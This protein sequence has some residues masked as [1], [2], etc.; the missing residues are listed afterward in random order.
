MKTKFVCVV[1]FV[2]IVV[3]SH[4]AWGQWVRTGGPTGRAV[5]KLMATD[6][7]LY[8][9]VSGVSIHRSTD[10]GNTWIHSDTSVVPGNLFDLFPFGSLLVAATDSGVFLS[11]NKGLAWSRVVGLLPPSFFY[12]ATSH[13]SIL[14]VGTNRDGI[15]RSFDTGRTWQQSNAGLPA[16][17]VYSLKTTE[18]NVLVGLS[19]DSVGLYSSTDDGLHWRPIH[20]LS[21]HTDFLTL[22]E[23][24]PYGTRVFAWITSTTANF[25]CSHL[26]LSEDYGSTWRSITGGCGDFGP[27]MVCYD[28]AAWRSTIFLAP[29]NLGRWNG[30]D[31]SPDTGKT[32]FPAN[33]GLDDTIVT[34]LV[35]KGDYIFAGTSTAGVWKRP[36]SQITTSAPMASSPMPPDFQ[37]LNNYPNPFNPSTTIRYALPTRAHVTLTV[38]NTLGQ[39]VATLVSEVQEAGYHDVRFDASGLASGVYLYRLQA[40][41]YVATKRLVL[42][43]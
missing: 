32:W 25:F 31:F 17:A 36:L 40:G 30:F 18:A 22:A 1:A 9:G 15:Y 7:E 6:S 13:N 19:G 10:D 23:M 5:V 4:E 28:V 34:A 39:Q 11:A 27:T 43:R 42:V 35:V 24:Y 16:R 3:L 20:P 26:A 12:R 38:F 37:L 14:F 21:F 33:T 8:A 41:E 29:Q 2:A